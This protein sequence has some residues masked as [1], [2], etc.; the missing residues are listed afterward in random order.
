MLYK[1]ISILLSLLFLL[2]G[3]S[4]GQNEKL[5]SSLESLVSARPDSLLNLVN[6]QE[7]DIKEIEKVYLKTLV[8]QYAGEYNKVDS[9]IT[10]AF[11]THSFEQDSMLYIKFLSLLADQ[12]KITDDFENAFKI[13]FGVVD[14][15]SRNN[16]NIMLVTTYI[17]MGELYRSVENFNKGLEYLEKAEKVVNQYDGNF[18][19]KIIARLY[20]RRAAIF[21]QSDTDYDSVEVLS[22]EVIR[23]AQE[24]GDK[25]LEASASNELGFLYQHREE[26][27]PEAEFYLKKAV[28]IW[29]EMGYDIYAANARINLAR[30]YDK[31]EE[32]DKA[33]AFLNEK[34]EF[35][36]ASDWQWEKGGYYEILG[37][38]YGKQKNYEKAYYYGNK[39]KEILLD[40]AEMQYA[41]RLSIMTIQL[42]LQRKED[43]LLKKQLEIDRAKL[44]SKI[45]EDE[46]NILYFT[47]IIVLMISLVIAVFWLNGRRQRSKLKKQHVQIA[48]ANERLSYLVMEKE[49]L[50][51]E[52]NHRVKNNLS[53]L[54]SLLYLQQRELKSD[55]AKKALEESQL[56]IRNMSLVHENLYTRDNMDKVNFQDYLGTLVT[57][58]KKVFGFEE[59]AIN[60][61]IECE[62]LVLDL[63]NSIP[64]AMIFNELITNSL[65]YAF[66]DIEKGEIKITYEANE[67]IYSDNGPGIL[68]DKKEGSLGLKLVKLFAT[69]LGATVRSEKTKDYFSYHICF[70]S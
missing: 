28:R 18:P 9:I 2:M 49:V 57:N 15:C 63:S 50:L 30:F 16:E 40:V 37:I 23:L 59:K 65:K 67:F 21:M 25:D 14:Y 12:K 31:A 58:L 42:E 4:Y 35:V 7:I 19:K 68:T 33:I 51:R 41:H 29:E 52:V 26:P 44:D 32:Y 66:S 46:N 13:L 55:A 22:K 24:I 5:M 36:D 61:T 69:Q 60:I 11:E 48:D 45:K 38:I 47:V 39:A 6:E 70:S 1:K 43:E 20:G 10:N 27:L 8:F 64:M 56:R 54:S 62:E 53:I 3:S 17:S 34:I